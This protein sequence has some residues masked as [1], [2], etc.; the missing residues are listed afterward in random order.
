MFV[1]RCCLSRSF[2]GAPAVEVSP[3]GVS[4]FVS[5]VAFPPVLLLCLVLQKRRL[6]EDAVARGV[7]KLDPSAPLALQGDLGLYTDVSGGPG[8]H[9]DIRCLA[10]SL[11]RSRAV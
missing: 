3:E 10:A 4:V 11:P 5:V 2:E 6:A 7:V 1:L 9:S 8:G